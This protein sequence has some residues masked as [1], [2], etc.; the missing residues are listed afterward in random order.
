MPQ[1][2]KLTV[3]SCIEVVP[4]FCLLY[5][6]L[7]ISQK[8]LILSDVHRN[9]DCHPATPIS[10]LAV[11]FKRANSHSSLPEVF[12]DKPT[13]SHSVLPST[14]S[15]QRRELVFDSDYRMH[16]IEPS[17]FSTPS[18]HS[19]H[20]EVSIRDEVFKEQVHVLFRT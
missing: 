16:D 11:T 19:L 15:H 10:P 4:L 2:R 1:Q 20:S 7:L 5:L 13:N 3:L 6:F 9:G 18:I 12:V 14:P 8:Y 17:I